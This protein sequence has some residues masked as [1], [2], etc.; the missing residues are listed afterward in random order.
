MLAPGFGGV[1]RG[2]ARAVA[3]AD[4]RLDAACRC[5]DRYGTGVFMSVWISEALSARAY[6]RTSSIT[7][8]KGSLSPPAPSPLL[9]MTTLAIAE[10]PSDIEAS[11][12]W[13]T[14]LM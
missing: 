11:V 10:V 2:G 14:P 5:R 3:T 13:R 12:F 4:E 8:L 6:S 1:H 9:P 7:P